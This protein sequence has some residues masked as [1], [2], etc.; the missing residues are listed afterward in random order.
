[1]QMVEDWS[2]REGIAEELTVSRRFQR[3]NLPYL[4]SPQAFPG[5]QCLRRPLGSGGARHAECSG[6]ASPSAP[7]LLQH[8]SRAPFAVRAR[9]S[10]VHGDAR[11]ERAR[12]CP[13]G[14]GGGGGS[15]GGGGGGSWLLR[16][17][18]APCPRRSRPGEWHHCSPETPPLDSPRMLLF[19]RSAPPGNF[20]VV[21]AS[22]N[23]V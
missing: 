16:A 4:G 19:S 14:G 11:R 2:D 1:M 15:G 7:D 8:V 10:H 18:P 22:G 13:G 5:T 17:A 3:D 6:A 23:A 12:Q 20:G 21:P 9:P